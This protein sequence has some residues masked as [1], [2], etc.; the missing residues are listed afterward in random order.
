MKTVVIGFVGTMLDRATHDSRWEK[1]RPTV[2]LCQ[3]DDLLID[4]FELICERRYNKLVEVIEADIALVSPETKVVRR[5]ISMRNP[6]DFQEMYGLLH[7]F[8]RDYPF[9]PENEEYLV[10]ITTGTHVAQICMFLL[11]EA[12]HIPGR[13][14]QTGPARNRRDAKGTYSI[15]DLDLTRYDQLA[16]RMEQVLR[17]DLTFLK[18]GIETCNAEYN[19]LIEQ[20]EKVAIKSREPILLMGAT[21]AGKSFLA[22][23]VHELKCHKMGLAGRF[24]E[25][26]CATLHGTN[27][28][29]TL[30]GH[31]KGAYTGATQDRKGLLLEADGGLLFLDEIGDLGPDEQAMLLKAIEEKRFYPM[32][33][34][35]EVE[36]DFQLICGTN[37]DLHDDV[38]KGSFRDDLFARINLWTF[39]LPG[40][41]ERPEDIEPNLQFELDRHTA[42]AK[43][44]VRFS[45]EARDRYL[46]FARSADALWKANFRD[47]G[48][49]V[50]R[51]ATLADAGRITTEIVDEEIQRLKCSWGGT[52]INEP[53]LQNYFS[54]EE[55]ARIDLFD[56]MQLAQVIKVCASSKSLADAGRRLFHVSRERRQS[57][58]DSD[59]LRKYLQKFGLDWST[60]AT[61]G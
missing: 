28:L 56:C 1:W 16:S 11:A 17:D 4:R 61:R 42:K 37:R 35:R 49:S 29:A 3:Q 20:I 13:L 53:E 27:A 34:D 32:G 23:R 36:S 45:K 19:A 7:D 22:R 50:T 41:K 43:Y 44:R 25:V 10:H 33:S 5:Y 9:D 51:M 24:I 58:N 48:S 30:F 46:R 40:L 55:L 14:V 8:A 6:W 21:G 15:I 52:A 59:R 2:A 39:S 18:A 31:R 57:S 47:L 38:R 12:R 26:N 60:I 54:D